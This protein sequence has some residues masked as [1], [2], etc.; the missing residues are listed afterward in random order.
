MNKKLYLGVDG[1]GTRTTAV[2]A[3]EK[4]NLIAKTVGDSINYY[5]MGLEVARKNMSDIIDELS[6]VTGSKHF[7]GAFVGMSA[8]NDK[9]QEEELVAFTSGVIDAE[10]IGMDSD[11][12]VAME[13]MLTD[14]PCAVVISGTG[15]MV[16]ARDENGKVHHTGGWGFILGDE[17]SG[18]DIAIKGIKSAIRGYEGS[19]PET[20]LSEI[21]PAFYDCENMDALI[22]VFYD[23]PMARKNIASFSRRVRESAAEGDAVCVDII[24]SSARDLAMTA[25]ALFKRFEYKF[26]I[27]LWGGIFQYSEMFRNE[28]NRI[29]NENGYE[30]D[31]LKFPPEIGAIFAAYKLCS[32]DITDSMLDNLGK[33]GC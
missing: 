5:S 3:D 4:G 25:L 7:E 10:K 32:N 19:A 33:G 12:F 17:G 24:L 26:R 18:Y 22:D 31:L 13:S 15:S 20:V 8:L 14:K 28:F 2:V 1:G 16:I 11:L 30:S 21:L 23:P 9:A 27:G 6:L 29:M